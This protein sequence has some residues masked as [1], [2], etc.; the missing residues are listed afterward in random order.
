MDLVTTL[1]HMLNAAVQVGD[2]TYPIKDGVARGVSDEHGA[3][4]LEQVNHVWQRCAA[5]E[6]PAAPQ[7]EGFDDCQSEDTQKP[8]RG[9]PRAAS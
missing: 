8:K 3:Q 7:P 9:R 6:P 1:P 2:K 5:P 4:L